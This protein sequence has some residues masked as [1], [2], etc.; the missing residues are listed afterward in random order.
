[1]SDDGANSV[2]PFESDEQ[3]FEANEARDS[4]D[5]YSNLVEIGLKMSSFC[6]RD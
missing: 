4:S 5:L 3:G 2:S 6:F 1:M